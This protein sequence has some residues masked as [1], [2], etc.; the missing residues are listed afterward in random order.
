MNILSFLFI[1][2]LQAEMPTQKISFS[3]GA[4]LE[5]EVAQTDAHRM[6][7][8][9]N[10][11]GLKKNS[12]MLF[13]FAVPQTL[14]FWMK[15]TYIPLSIGYFDKNKTLKEIHKL[16]PQN[17]MELKQDLK[18]YPSHCRCQ[19]AIEVNQGWFKRNK[20]KVGDN[21][22]ATKLEKMHQ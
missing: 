4:Q 18:S 2:F 15:D 1:S 13:I 3:S 14:S 8:L 19:Y 9:M 11:T 5:V 6:K 22:K 10:R 16:K 20:V 17:M 7:G 21:F 12:G